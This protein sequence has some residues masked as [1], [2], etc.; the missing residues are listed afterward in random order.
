MIFCAGSLSY[1]INLGNRVDNMVAILTMITDLFSSYLVT[2][3]CAMVVSMG[4]VPWYI[5]NVNFTSKYIYTARASVKKTWDSKCLAL[6]AQMVRA[7]GMNPKIGGSSPPQVETFSV[8]KT[9][10]LSQE[11]PFVSK[12]NAVVRAQLTFQML[13][14][15]QN[16]YIHIILL[17]YHLYLT[18]LVHNKWCRQHIV[19]CQLCYFL[20]LL[21]D[22]IWM[23]HMLHFTLHYIMNNM[24]IWV[25]ILK[26]NGIDNILNIM[27]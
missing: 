6:I 8:S 22:A 18:K 19:W 5:S 7:F 25:T 21:I 26:S 11:H 17:E 4:W 15:L 9:L 13:T 1:W 12:M 14:L 2:S 23:V 27:V 3:L 10:T 16:I 20:L 24:H